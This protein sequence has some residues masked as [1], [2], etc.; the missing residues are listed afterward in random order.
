MI[1]E[2]DKNGRIVIPSEMKKK[3]SWGTG[4]KL[5]FSIVGKAVQLNK[6]FVGCSVCNKS[7]NKL[8]T[9][10]NFTVCSGCL[11]KFIAEVKKERDKND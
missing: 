10:N 8:Y 2:I 5:K 1:R 3:L 7:Q 6:V 4:T 11:K 9:V